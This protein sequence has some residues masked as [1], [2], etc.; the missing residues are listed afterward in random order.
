MQILNYY[1]SFP[2]DELANNHRNANR[3]GLL[4]LTA[5]ERVKLA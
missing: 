5:D 3:L 2:D 1:L 4:D